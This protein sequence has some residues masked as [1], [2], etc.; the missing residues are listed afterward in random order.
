MLLLQLPPG[1]GLLTLGLSQGPVIGA[2]VQHTYSMP[3]EMEMDVLP[4]LCAVQQWLSL[5]GVAL[6]RTSMSVH[7]CRGP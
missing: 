7:S 4:Q 2:G 5:D 1:R 3:L 6:R